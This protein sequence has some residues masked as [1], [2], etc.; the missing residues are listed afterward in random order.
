MDSADWDRRYAGTALLWS[1]EPNQ[2]VVEQVSRLRPGRVL[3]LACG[4]GR[5]CVWLATHGWRATGVDFSSVALGQAR[6]L[7]HRF[8]ATPEWIEADLTRWTPEFAAYDLVLVTYL[9]LDAIDRR[10]VL[11]AASAALA[12]GGTLLVLGHDRSNLGTGTSGPRDP[13]ILLDADELLDDLAGGPPLRI[14]RAGRIVRRV[15]TDG[16]ERDA[17]DACVVGVRPI[18]SAGA[19]ERAAELAAAGIPAVLPPRGYVVVHRYPSASELRRLRTAAGLPDP[20]PQAAQDALDNSLAGLCLEAEDEPGR[21]VACG[22]IV[23]DGRTFLVMV[24]IAVDPTVDP[25]DQTAKFLAALRGPNDDVPPPAETPR[26]VNK[27]RP[28]N[29]AR[30]TGRGRTS[31]GRSTGGNRPAGTDGRSGRQGASIVAVVLAEL[32]VWAGEHADATAFV[33]VATRTG[34]APVGEWMEGRA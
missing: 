1:A 9:H 10:S 4:E 13:A 33:G 31:R 18:M 20:G 5:N 11:R 34:V 24:D 22:R 26:V 8:D 16:R 3:D 2:F 32:S 25:S 30:S 21:A 23:G 6:E 7:A 28:P 17:I 12:P 29:R 14:V 19:G 15:T 27:V